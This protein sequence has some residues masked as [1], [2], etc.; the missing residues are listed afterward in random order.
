[1]RMPQQGDATVREWTDI[2]GRVRFGSLSPQT[3]R[4]RSP[5]VINAVAQ[6][7]ATYADPDGSRVFP[8]LVRLAVTLEIEYETAKDAVGVLRDLG[9]IRLVRPGRGPGDSNEYQLS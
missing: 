6:R 5:L 4:K 8:G 3:R 1:M 7:L 9:L 2:L